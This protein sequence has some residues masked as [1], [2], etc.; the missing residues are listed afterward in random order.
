[1]EV[2][3]IGCCLQANVSLR[4]PTLWREG[5]DIVLEAKSEDPPIAGEGIVELTYTV[6]MLCA[7]IGP[8]AE[9]LDRG[10]NSPDG[11]RAEVSW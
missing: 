10:S 8:L 7:T 2:K 4:V 6:V 5:G 11:E 9:K 1:M 3:D